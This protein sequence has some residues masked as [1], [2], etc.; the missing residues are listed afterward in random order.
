MYNWYSFLFDC[1]I[2]SFNDFLLFEIWKKKVFE[3]L[4]N[5]LKLFIEN[6]KKKIY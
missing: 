4:I 2:G 1:E 3:N 5:F 6:F